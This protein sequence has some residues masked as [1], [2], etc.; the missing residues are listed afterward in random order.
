MTDRIIEIAE[1]PAALSVRHQQLIIRTDEAETSAPLA[2]IAVLV[3][4]HPRVTY[5][6]SVLTGLVENGGVSVLCGPDYLPTAMTLPLRANSEQAERFRLQAAASLPLRKRAWQQIVR[7]KIRA[8]GRVL[9]EFEKNSVLVTA[10]ER[11]VGSG[12]PS[13]VEAHAA[14]RY[15]RALFGDSF[16]RDPDAADQ[17][18]HLNYGYAILRAVTARAL[19]AAGLHPSFGLHHTNRYNAFA[20][21]DDLM[22]P[23][24]PLVD[25]AVVLWLADEE[26]AGP[27]TQVT[28]RYLLTT[29]TGE[30]EW[31]GET[32]TLFDWMGRVAASLV[33]VLKGE[34]E[35]LVLPEM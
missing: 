35:S 29:I 14:R 6:H 21:A 22:E 8:Q 32:R 4:A 11:T 17:N 27:F 34:A 28:R 1:T 2:D 26:P 5:S 20:L 12:D 23:F 19:C 25:R 30:S 24:R 16:R 15:W 7:A 13:N 3:I 31:Q 9:A 33:R 10:L 18:R